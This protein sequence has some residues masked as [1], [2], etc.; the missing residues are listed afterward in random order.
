MI[1]KPLILS[2]LI[3]APFIVIAG[4]PLTVFYPATQGAAM[5]MLNYYNNFNQKQHEENS[6]DY[7]AA[8]ATT[9]ASVLFFSYKITHLPTISEKIIATACAVQTLANIHFL[10]KSVYNIATDTV[11]QIYDFIYREDE[12]RD[13]NLELAGEL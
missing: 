6:V 3:S 13:I 5:G 8:F 4:F 2:V 7:V 10:S 1:V 12:D 9:S 11:S